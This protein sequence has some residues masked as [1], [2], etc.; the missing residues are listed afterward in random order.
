MVDG[1]LLS[2]IDQEHIWNTFNRR[3]L[4]IARR[5][6]DRVETLNPERV[7]GLTCED[8]ILYAGNHQTFGDILLP[9]YVILMQGWPF[10]RS[11]AKRSMDK[12][13]FRWFMD[14]MLGFDIRKFGV[15]WVDNTKVGNEA[16]R[17]YSR[18]M[19]TNFE[20]GSSLLIFPEGHRYNNEDG[21]PGKFRRGPFAAVIGNRDEI[22]CHPTKVVCFAGC[23]NR[24][25]ESEVRWAYRL[26]KGIGD[27][28]SPVRW[29]FVRNKGV[30]RI[31]FG[32]PFDFMDAA[33]EGG[34]KE[35]AGRLAQRCETE[36]RSL[37]TEA[38][39]Y[40]E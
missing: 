38:R 25:P 36:V 16:F 28:V 18:A 1:E 4:G 11:V 32:E 39:T 12:P 31:N 5:L 14:K 29:Q 10:P 9:H 26:G 24:V 13:A 15:L 6:V 34:F 40:S 8:R 20:A 33:G 22:N 17:E 37:L 27:V 3:G 30:A 2:E 23:Y 21:M 19:A 7:S 35:R